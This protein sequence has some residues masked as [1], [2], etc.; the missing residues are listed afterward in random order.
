MRRLP[1]PCRNG[2]FR[3]HCPL[4]ICTIRISHSM[5]SIR[6]SICLALFVCF[7]SSSSFLSSAQYT[8][9]RPHLL[10]QASPI[11]ICQ[12]S[13]S[14]WRQV[15]QYG[16]SQSLHISPLYLISMCRYG[17]PVS[18]QTLSLRRSTSAR[19]S[20]FFFSASLRSKSSCL[21]SLHLRFP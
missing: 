17:P 15:R 13:L 9:L 1:R 18:F 19:L 21:S 10:H 20:A 12:D 4:R 8:I 6:L 14:M 5:V 3:R 16:H 2:K 11:P 7:Y